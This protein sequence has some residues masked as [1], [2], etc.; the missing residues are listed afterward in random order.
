MTGLHS[1]PEAYEFW[2]PRGC[3]AATNCC[4]ACEG[5]DGRLRNRYRWRVLAK[6]S[7]LGRLSTVLTSLTDHFIKN[8]GSSD[9]DISVDI[10]PVSM[11]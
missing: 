8:G 5:A 4:G 10:D 6:C 7:S 2:L 1:R 9:A 3:R 11:M